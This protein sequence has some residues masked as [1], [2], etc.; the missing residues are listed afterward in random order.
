[1]DRAIERA[2]T[3]DFWEIARADAL[4]NETANY[5]PAILATI[6]LAN[7]PEVYGLS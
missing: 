3:R 5:V 6:T 1:M 2:G 7:D 4:P